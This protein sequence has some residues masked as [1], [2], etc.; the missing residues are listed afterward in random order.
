MKRLLAAASVLGVGVT[1]AAATPASA[2]DATI[3][4]RSSTGALIARATWDDSHDNLCVI[5]LVKGRKMTATITLLD[6]DWG[7]RSVSDS[8]LDSTPNCTGN[9]AIPEDKRAFVI[10]GDVNRSTDG[11]FWT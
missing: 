2:A 5:S 10:V 9:L 7:P 3:P 4:L 1:L 6:Q 11:T 8:G